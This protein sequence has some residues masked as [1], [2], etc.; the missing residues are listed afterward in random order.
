MSYA[1]NLGYSNITPNS[2]VNSNYVNVGNTNYAAGFSSNEIPSSGL[3]AAKNNINAAAGCIPGSGQCGGGSKK[4]KNIKQLYRMRLSMRKRFRKSRGL[5]KGLSKRM[6]KIRQTLG[7][8]F[9]RKNRSVRRRR[10]RGGVQR[11]G[12]QRGGY[13]QYQNNLPLTPSYQTAGV[14]LSAGNSALANPTP[15]TANNVNCTDNY[16]HYSGAGFPSKG[17]G[18]QP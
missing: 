1:S 18:A 14:H 11:G 17:W 8:R 2:N 4:F 15:Y 9:S 10:Q 12:V 5:R 6:R 3:F 16:N 7:H 13:S